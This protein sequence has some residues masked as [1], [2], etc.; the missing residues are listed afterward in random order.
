MGSYKVLLKHF[1]K[2]FDQKFMQ[3]INIFNLVRK[4]IPMS[5]SLNHCVYI[6]AIARKDQ[7]IHIYE[8]S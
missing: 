1:Y 7:K 2:K 4:K 5:K 8:M 3:M 6:I